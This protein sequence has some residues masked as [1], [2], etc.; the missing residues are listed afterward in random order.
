LDHLGLERRLG[1]IDDVRRRRPGAPGWRTF[2]RR[3]WR[4]LQSGQVDGTGQPDVSGAHAHALHPRTGARRT[5]QATVNRST[6]TSAPLPPLWWVPSTTS[7][8][9][10]TRSASRPIDR[11]TRYAVLV[12]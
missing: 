4:G 3:L 2:R 7:L 8:R 1:H 5:D 12:A 11:W 10:C 9:V 6:V